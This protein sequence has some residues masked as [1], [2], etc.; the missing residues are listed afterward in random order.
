M[1]IKAFARAKIN[2]ALHVTGLREDGYHL[3]DSLVA[4]AETGD[5]ITVEAAETLTLT[6][7]GPQSANLSSTDN[8][9]LKAARVLH[10]TH[11]AQITLDKHLPIA[12]GIGGG[13]ADAAA[14]LCALSQLWSAPLPEPDVILTLG[15]DVPVCLA[16]TS[17]RMQGIGE[18]IT[19]VDLPAAWLVLINPG[20]ALPT[21]TVFRRLTT[22]NNPPLGPLPQ[23]PDAGSLAAYLQNQRNDLEPPASSLAPAIA[24]ITA[25][26]KAQPSCLL[27]RM[28]GSG[29]TCF[30]LFASQS[31]A[32]SA[33]RNLTHANPAY[34]ITA[35]A[36]SSFSSISPLEAGD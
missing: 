12:S 35:A 15:A 6:I 8:L 32:A 31:E 21:A 28:S 2:L 23:F 4:F 3:L 10:P 13:S 16:G 33:A 1:A 27:A 14:A 24:T 20:I 17:A 22:R 11:G 19:P 9:V 25:A 29:A 36:L 18:Q 34:W 7:T 30:G 26:L 5:L